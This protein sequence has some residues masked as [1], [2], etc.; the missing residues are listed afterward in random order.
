MSSKPIVY[1]NRSLED[2]ND[3]NAFCKLCI[4]LLYVKPLSFSC[5]EKINFVIRFLCDKMI[6]VFQS[7]DD[8]FYIH[9]SIEYKY[10]VFPNNSCLNQ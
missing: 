5:I 6:K 3:I 1:S 10:V 2:F 7:I 4:L 8:L 9:T